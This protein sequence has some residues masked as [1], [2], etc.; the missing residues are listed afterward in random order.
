M[1]WKKTVTELKMLPNE[2]V[3]ALVSP[4]E[5]RI[6]FPHMRGVPSTLDL[7]TLHDSLC[8]PRRAISIKHL[9]LPHLW[10]TLNKLFNMFKLHEEP[11]AHL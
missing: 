6:L 7:M 9:A 5:A 8:V 4:R 11:S 2:E 3:P 10:P 1:A